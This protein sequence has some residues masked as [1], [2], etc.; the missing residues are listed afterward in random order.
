M[1][2]QLDENYK[3]ES[4]STAFVLYRRTVP[5]DKAK[6]P[7]YTAVSYNNDLALALMSYNRYVQ[8]DFFKESKDIKELLEKLEEI[9]QIIKKVGEQKNV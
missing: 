6:E 8:K 4:D 5:K 9:K 7:Y 2:L 3:I 1:V